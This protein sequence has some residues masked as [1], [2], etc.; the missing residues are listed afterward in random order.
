MSTSVPTPTIEQNDFFISYTAEDESWAEW[1]GWRL[2]DAG[3]RV[4]LQAWDF[5][6]GGNFVLLMQRATLSCR[7]TLVVLTDA[8]LEAMFT[9]SEWAAD[10]RLDPCGKN[11]ALLPVRVKHCKKDPGLLGPIVYIDL[12]DCDE[13]QAT[14]KLLA[15]IAPGRAKPSSKPPFPGL[16]LPLPAAPGEGSH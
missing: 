4:V 12:V 9:Q 7:R 15:G 13:D 10:F 2:E 8:Y 16:A 6:P 3:H 14:R 11:G 5:R 1:I